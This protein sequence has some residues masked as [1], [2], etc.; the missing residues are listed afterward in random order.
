MN[1]RIDIAPEIEALCE[2]FSIDKSDVG[3]IRIYPATIEFDV[4]LKRD[5][6]KYVNEKTHGVGWTLRK[7]DISS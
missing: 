6:K 1:P 5:G 7:F 2:R 3:A 4:F